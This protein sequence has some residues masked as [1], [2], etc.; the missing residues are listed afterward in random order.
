[1][2]DQG[3]RLM[4]LKFNCFQIASQKNSS[5]KSDKLFCVW[6]ILLQAKFYAEFFSSDKVINVWMVNILVFAVCFFQHHK[7]WC[8]QKFSSIKKWM[9]PEI[10]DENVFKNYDIA[11]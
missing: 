11:K 9:M 8:L 1:M 5:V 7:K 2:S 3:K 4:F 6:L 10:V